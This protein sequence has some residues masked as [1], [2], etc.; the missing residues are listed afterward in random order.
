MTLEN[1]EYFLVAAE[2]LNFTEAARRLFITQQTLSSHISRIEKYYGIKLFD[3]KPPMSL[4]PEGVELEKRVR[5]IIRMADDTKKV[6][7]DLKDYTMT[8]VTIGITGNRGRIYLPPVIR[9]IHELYPNIRINISEGSVDEV[10]DA[11]HQGKV[12]FS[13]STF[14]RYTYNVKS[15][16]FWTER[17]AAA[18][19][20]SI[21][22]KYLA[23]SRDKLLAD[24]GHADWKVL[25]ACPFIALA[26]TIRSGMPFY[27]ICQELGIRPNIILEG[28]SADALVPICMDGMGVLVCPDI[29]FYPYRQMMKLG[30]Q[31]VYILTQEEHLSQDICVNYLK[32]KYLSAASR[33]F[34]HILRNESYAVKN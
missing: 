30:N 26:P 2:E 5:E 12:D 29:F 14:P 18:V 22:E 4:T 19:P 6:M 11:M 32:N 7:Q 10:E 23:G 21:M 15:I 3:R 13:V 28:K 33:A 25:E 31:R 17:L 20:Q 1:L 27:Q 16:P 9:K 34:I 8:S 24:P